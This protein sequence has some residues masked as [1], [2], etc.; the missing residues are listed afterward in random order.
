MA[1]DT[2]EN[3]SL[4]VAN[5]GTRTVL[6][7]SIGHGMTVI[8]DTAEARDLQ[9]FYT[10]KTVESGFDIGLAFI[11]YDRFR[12]WSAWMQEY[13]R[14]LGAG[15]FGPMRVKCPKFGFDKLGIPSSPIPFGDD[16]KTVIYRVSMTLIGATNPTEVSVNN[17]LIS[18]FRNAGNDTTIAPYF[19]PS[20]QK[21]VGG[22]DYNWVQDIKDMT[23]ADALGAKI[24]AA[25]DLSGGGQE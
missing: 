14:R 7:E 6:L 8:S 3:A 1:H 21:A 2:G 10:T 12:S 20:G 4:S 18:Q 22:D 11:S 19:Y 13:L 17:K 9:A 25:A 5:Y 23:D 16:R 24:G 15:A